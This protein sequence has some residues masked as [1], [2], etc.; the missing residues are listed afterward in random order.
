MNVFG[1]DTLST[2]REKIGPNGYCSPNDGR[3]MNGGCDKTNHL[4]HSFGNDFVV[5][6][7]VAA[8]PK[9]PAPPPPPAP[10][11]PPAPGK[12][13]HAT[14]A[15]KGLDTTA[16]PITPPMATPTADGESISTESIPLT[17]HSQFVSE[18]VGL[19]TACAAACCAN[20]ECSGYTF[21]PE[22]DDDSGL[23]ICKKGKPCCWL[24]RGAGG[25]QKGRSR[26]SSA[27]FGSIPP[28]P[29]TPPAPSTGETEWPLWVPPGQW[30]EWFGG[31]LHTGPTRLAFCETPHTQQHTTNSSSPPTAINAHGEFSRL[32]AAVCGVVCVCVCVCVR[33]RDTASPG[34]TPRPRSLCWSR[35]ARSSR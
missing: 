2:L 8:A 15:G 20:H 1:T 5:S 31:T 16:P 34:S 26:L 18:T 13:C 11:A 12:V 30:V 32:T 9:F 19:P 21:D 33:V 25:T 3:G 28:A 10:P 35:L 4:Q 24:K 22:Q 17:L 27:Y 6:P 29:P 14:A 23:P 7:I